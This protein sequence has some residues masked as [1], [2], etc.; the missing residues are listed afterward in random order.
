MDS[1]YSMENSPLK[2]HTPLPENTLLATHLE[3]WER[4][5]DSF[6]FSLSLRATRGTA[7][8]FDSLVGQT[9]YATIEQQG[10]D[11]RF[12]HGEVWKL[13]QEDS[14]A[15]FDHYTMVLKPRLAR[16]ALTRRSRI[17]QNQSAID[18][19]KTV[20]EPVGGA[21]FDGIFG[22]P[23]VRTYCTPTLSKLAATPWHPTAR[24]PPGRKT[25]N[26][27]PGFSMASSRLAK[28]IAPR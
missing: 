17:F 7:I 8:R 11:K 28:T 12:V 18:I 4:L 25:H 5:G 15:T 21:N 27:L 6:E 9:A 3:G 1:M 14:D 2:V 26:R 16:L 19:L 23:P 20:L 13:S 22:E 24:W 10:H